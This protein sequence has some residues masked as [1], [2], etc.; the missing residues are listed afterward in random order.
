MLAVLAERGRFWRWDADGGIGMGGFFRHGGSLDAQHPRTMAALP[1]SCANLGLSGLFGICLPSVPPSFRTWKIL[2]KKPCFFTLL[3]LS[4][5]LCAAAG[6]IQSFPTLSPPR[7]S[8]SLLPESPAC[9]AELRHTMAP[10]SP[11]LNYALRLITLRAEFVDL[12]EVSTRPHPPNLP[13]PSF[14]NTIP[15]LKR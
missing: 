8:V 14:S 2:R 10:L 7:A 13:P 1:S 11:L 5:L 4:V 15:K 3:G 6:L 9:S 12:Q